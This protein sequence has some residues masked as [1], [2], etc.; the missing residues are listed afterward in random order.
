MRSSLEGHA[1][2][3]YTFLSSTKLRKTTAALRHAWE[4]TTPG[5]LSSS[6]RRRDTAVGWVVKCPRWR[7]P[8]E[9]SHYNSGACR[10]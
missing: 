5:L 8:V 7:R 10:L 1:K 9:W 3:H 4:P 2:P 6:P